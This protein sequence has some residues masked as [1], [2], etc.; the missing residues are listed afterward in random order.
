MVESSSVVDPSLIV[1]LEALRGN[2]VERAGGKAAN[3]G[4]LIAGGFPVPPGFCVTVHA[5]RQVTEAAGLA[6]SIEVALQTAESAE[7]GAARIA[8]LFASLSMPSDLA[9]SI[10]AA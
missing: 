7:D 4:E 10:A 8:D 1:P 2:D 6:E 5:Y 3:L 9:A